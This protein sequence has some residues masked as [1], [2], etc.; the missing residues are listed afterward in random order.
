MGIATLGLWTWNLQQAADKLEIWGFSV[1]K[2]TQIEEQKNQALAG[3]DTQKQRRINS[4]FESI[5][6][7]SPIVNFLIILKKCIL[8][9]KNN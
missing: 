2:A 8:K 4:L 7:I 3:K 9:K 5:K 1:S 6:S